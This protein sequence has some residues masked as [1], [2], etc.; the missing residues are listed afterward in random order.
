MFQ[1]FLPQEFKDSSGLRRLRP[2][3][4]EAGT[5]PE[6]VVGDLGPVLF[7]RTPIPSFSDHLYPYLTLEEVV[8]YI[9][10]PV[11]FRLPDTERVTRIVERLPFEAA[12]RW[13]AL[14]QRV[15]A[16]RHVEPEFQEALAREVYGDRIGACFVRALRAFEGHAVAIC[17]PQLFAL[18]RLLVLHARDDPRAGAP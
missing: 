12:M 15:L 10:S 7:A 16:E 5:V 14:V 3:S 11:P 2:P 13:T 1:I 18:Q 9:D 8:R 6:G 17:E 4:P